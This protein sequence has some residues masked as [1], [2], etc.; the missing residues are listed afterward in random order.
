MSVA[1]RNI[2]YTVY[3]VLVFEGRDPDGIVVSSQKHFAT[4]GETGLA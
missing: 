1:V 4:I 3:L 2:E